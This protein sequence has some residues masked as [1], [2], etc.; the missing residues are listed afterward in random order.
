MPT[1]R[2]PSQD[3]DEIELPAQPLSFKKA[4]ATPVAL[5]AVKPSDLQRE[6]PPAVPVAGESPG[7]ELHTPNTNEPGEEAD[8]TPQFSNPAETERALNRAL[9]G[10]AAHPES[11]TAVTA[12][13]PAAKPTR[14]EALLEQLRQAQNKDSQ[15]AALNGVANNLNRASSL[16]LSAASP[17]ERQKIGA[18]QPS[19]EPSAV[20]QLE[21]RINLERQGK[22]DARKELYSGLESKI[23]GQKVVSG[24]DEAQKRKLELKEHLERR[25][26]EDSYD[27][28]DSHVA[29]QLGAAA[30]QTAGMP[31]EFVQFMKNGNATTIYQ[32][33]PALQEI[34]KTQVQKKEAEARISE[35]QANRAETAEHHRAMEHAAQDRADKPPAGPKEKPGAS[36][37]GIFAKV[38]PGMSPPPDKESEE[39]RK[40]LAAHHSLQAITNGMQDIFRAHGG[41][42][43]VAGTDAANLGALWARAVAQINKTENLTRLSKEEV[44]LFGRQLG[45]D[46]EEIVNVVK[47][48]A[49]VRKLRE[50]V[51][52][53]QKNNA[54][55][56]RRKISVWPQLEP[57]EVFG[58]AGSGGGMGGE[59]NIAEPKSEAEYNALPPGTK[60]RKDGKVMQ[61]PGGGRDAVG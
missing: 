55:E 45:G 36:D 11:E 24:E 34:V 9:G 18:A 53:Y 43:P 50:L 17:S 47:D 51:S 41:N 44:K 5:P 30:A 3:E 20:G 29:Q 37:F 38:K 42:A 15:G 60:Y 12:P 1:Y 16:I 28:I 54:S 22:E 7:Q 10:E 27:S 49:G 8:N 35:S 40:E 19:P 61:K 39:L 23:L 25:A 46:P 59:A 31:P 52:S 33:F 2:T 14:S 6:I 32:H 56:A 58:G 26:R 13:Q 4:R 21:Q 57:G 48:A